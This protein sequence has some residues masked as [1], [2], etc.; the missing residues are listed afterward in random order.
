[1]SPSVE[2]HNCEANRCKSPPEETKQDAMSHLKECQKKDKAIS[3][4]KRQS[5][6][7]MLLNWC[8]KEI[9]PETMNH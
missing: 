3:A 8:L 2:C 5:E 1:M 9:Q 7:M 4:R 6:I